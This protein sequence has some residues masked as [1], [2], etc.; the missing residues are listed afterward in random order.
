MPPWRQIPPGWPPARVAKLAR[1]ACEEHRA[2]IEQQVALGRN[3]QAIYQDL[4][5]RFGFGQR[6]NS[7]KRLV[8]ALRRREPERFDILESLPGEEA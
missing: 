5:E 1:S 4:V 7:V 3:A 6:Y 2:W 8:R